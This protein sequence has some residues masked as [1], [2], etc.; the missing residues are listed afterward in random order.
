[1]FVLAVCIRALGVNPVIA[2]PQI[3]GLVPNGLSSRFRGRR[4]SD[5]P[6][7]LVVI[8]PAVTP[9]LALAGICKLP[10]SPIGR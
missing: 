7:A 8:K 9:I 1:M 2:I 4:G 10:T 6:C 5:G 3:H